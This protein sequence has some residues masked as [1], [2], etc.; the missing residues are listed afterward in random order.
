MVVEMQLAREKSRANQQRPEVAFIV[1]HLVVVHLGLRAQ[2]QA[3][4]GKLQEPFSPPSRHIDQKNSAR[5]QKLPRLQQRYR[6][7]VKMLQ[8]GNEKDHIEAL[9][10]KTRKCLLDRP[11]VALKTGECLDLR[12]DR[13]VHCDRTIEPIAKCDQLRGAKAATEFHSPQ[14]LAVRQPFPNRTLREP[15][16]ESIHH[17]HPVLAVA[18]VR[19]LAAQDCLLATRCTISESRVNPN[20][21]NPR[22]ISS[23]PNIAPCEKSVSA[24][25]CRT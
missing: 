3:K 15:H 7:F 6:R 8:D 11:F 14:S 13:E 4:C 2:A 9:L 21:W 24:N 12:R 16:T 23:N 18:D 10:R 1:I 17:T 20:V 25:P 5:L 19:T 22:M